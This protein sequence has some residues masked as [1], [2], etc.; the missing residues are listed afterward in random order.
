MMPLGC[1]QIIFVSNFYAKPMIVGG[2]CLFL[3]MT[4]SIIQWYHLSGFNALPTIVHLSVCLSCIS[5]KLFVTVVYHVVVHCHGNLVMLKSVHNLTLWCLFYRQYNSY[6]YSNSHQQL[7]KEKRNQTY[8]AYMLILK[9]M[10]T[11]KCS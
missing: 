9:I 11:K 4:S 10:Y 8:K 1:Y 5:L 3:L 6:K 2:C 7:Y